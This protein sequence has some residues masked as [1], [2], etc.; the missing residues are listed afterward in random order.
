MDIEFE[1]K[2]LNI[3]VEEISNR[4]RKLEAKESPEYLLRRYVFDVVTEDFG[5]LR[6][7]EYNGKATLT[8]KAK[9]KDDST[10]GQT[11]EIEIEVSDFEKTAEILKKLP[12]KTYY[13]QENKRKIF[14]LNDVEYNID[15][16]PRIK[17]YLEIEAKSKVELQVALKLLDL[18]GKDVGDKD[19]MRIYEDAGINLHGFTEMK[20]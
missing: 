15:T 13:Y 8:Y 9:V 3:N 10:I 17:P 7:R 18:E 11:K 2:I 6:L 16:W 20:F 4:L 19:V 12:H 1:T 14:S 5:F